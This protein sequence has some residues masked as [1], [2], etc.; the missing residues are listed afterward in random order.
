MA[1][2]AIPQL[3]EMVAPRFEAASSFLVVTLEDGVVTGRRTLVCEGPEGYRRIRLI[4]IHQISTLICNGINASFIDML[5]A[6]GV[7]VIPKCSL[8]VEEALEAYL[9]GSLADEKYVP[10]EVAQPCPITH[11]EL[12]VQARGLFETHGYRVNPGPGPDAFLIDLV[13]EIEC[14][15]CHNP[16]RVA[17]CCG[18][19]TYRARQEIS[20]FHHATRMGYHA[21]AYICPRQ[22]PIWKCCQEYGI[23][24]LDPKSR[25]TEER[26]ASRI[27]LLRGPIS[28]HEPAARSSLEK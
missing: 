8:S 18:A 28:G 15:V 24:P 27:P 20:E 4:Q 17:V 11:E 5:V 6:S 14:P 21:R 12:L 26:P 16:V 23:E 19:H 22:E 10:D 9:N 25:E 3:G 7:T 2:V 1:K 13:A